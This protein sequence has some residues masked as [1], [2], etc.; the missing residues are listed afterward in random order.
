MTGRK[1]KIG[2]KVKRRKKG[3]VQGYPIRG[4]VIGYEGDSMLLGLSKFS[5]FGWVIEG[6]S[7]SDRLEKQ[8]KKMKIKIGWWVNQVEFEKV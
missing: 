1:F 7:T 8:A 5:K 2:D 3:L 6:S 4:T